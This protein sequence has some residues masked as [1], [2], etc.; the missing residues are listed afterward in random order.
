MTEHRFSAEVRATGRSGHAVE[1]P[2]EFAGAL[3]GRRTPV[4]A[5]VDGVE[6]RARVG[7]YSGKVYLWL[8]QDLLR[9]IGRRAGDAVEV[10]VVVEAEPEAETPAEVTE[11]PE[12]V[13]ALTEDEAAR[14]A[15]AALSPEHRREYWA[16][17]GGADGPEVRADRVARTLR[18][19][20]G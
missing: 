14:T 12:L 17:I 2:K 19:L 5:H 11:P 3:A 20:R 1:V 7:A 4:L 13:A 6:Y 15:Y 16:W 10:R 9:Q 8:R 18:R